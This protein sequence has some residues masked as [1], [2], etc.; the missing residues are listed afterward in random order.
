MKINDEILYLH[1]VIE[2]AMSGDIIK[3]GV[4]D[5]LFAWGVVA[6]YNE[7]NNDLEKLS[8]QLDT[9]LNL[10]AI[11][12]NFDLFT[13]LKY[14][15]QNWLYVDFEE[16]YRKENMDMPRITYTTQINTLTDYLPNGVK[17]YNVNPDVINSF[18]NAMHQLCDEDRLTDGD[19]FYSLNAGLNR[20]LELLKTVEKKV[21]NPQIHLYKKLWDETY[22]IYDNDEA[23]AEY[24]EWIEEND[25]P[26]LNDLKARQKQEIFKL[27]SKNFFRFC[28]KPT[29]AEVKKYKTFISEDD[30]PFGT[31]IPEN[32]A[33]ECAKFEKF[34]EWKG[35]HIFLINYEKLGQYIYKHYQEFDDTE[36]FYIT[37]FD[38]N[39][40]A[41][42]EAMAS[43][44]PSLLPYLKNY[45]EKMV[46]GLV[47]WSV[48]VLSTCKSHL[49]ENVSANF[50]R[51]YMQKLLY[52]NEMKDEARKKL[53]SSSKKTFIC[54]IVAQLKNARIIKITVDNSVLSHS[55]HEKI[56]DISEDT[57]GKNIQRAYNANEG[58]LYVWTL[59]NIETIKQQSS[60]PFAGII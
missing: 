57:I 47:D 30:L 39:I 48:D 51:I 25:S 33:M 10:E 38:R 44:K 34:I 24:N 41:I 15:T 7:I 22:E 11:S 53:S 12:I 26:T 32:I 1:R 6:L 13:N 37:D 55:L 28:N 20:M 46:D 18:K 40:N 36:F 52:D 49:N 19:V 9:E 3:I 4:F 29:G 23:L 35:E 42:H 17:G 31:Q 8:I 27:L 45:E 21:K 56:N 43:L 2:G 59:K 50:F 16:L 60:N 58:A 54:N 14:W 5:R